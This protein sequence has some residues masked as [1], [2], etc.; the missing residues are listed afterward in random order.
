MTKHTTRPDDPTKLN[1]LPPYKIIVGDSAV[2]GRGVFATSRITKGEI[3]ERCPLIQM[4]YRSNYQLDPKIFGYMYAQPPCSCEDCEKHGVILHM[5]LGYGMLYNH[6]DVSNA[7]WKFNYSQLF[8]DVIAITDIKI[9]E[10]IF[11]GYGNAYFDSEN[12]KTGK[13]KITT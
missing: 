13:T 12:I 6:Q 9:K 10:E 3:I 8:A 7:V 1:Y 5:V 11:V 2:H 4:D